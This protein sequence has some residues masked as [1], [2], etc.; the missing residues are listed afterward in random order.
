M[1]M[2]SA[3]PHAPAPATVIVVTSFDPLVPPLALASV[4]PEALPGCQLF[5]DI[6]TAVYRELNG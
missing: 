4:Q 6:E 3:V 2:A 1:L 5:V